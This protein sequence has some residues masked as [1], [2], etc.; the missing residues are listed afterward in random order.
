MK[1]FNMKLH[2][3]ENK[4]DGYLAHHFFTTWLSLFIGVP[5]MILLSVTFC[6]FLSCLL[7][8]ALGFI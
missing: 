1:R 3:L 8:K 6:S 2:N 5:L 4:A 7:F